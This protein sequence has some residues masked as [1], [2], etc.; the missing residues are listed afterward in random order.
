MTTVVAHE[1]IREKINNIFFDFY[2][3]QM[4]FNNLIDKVNKWKT[5]IILKYFL[6][7]L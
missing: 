6:Q 5:Y 2:K 1:R 3:I 4:F 7:N